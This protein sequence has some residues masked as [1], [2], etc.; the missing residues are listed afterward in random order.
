M[1]HISING[2]HGVKDFA[3][4]IAIFTEEEPVKPLFQTRA[5]HVFCTFETRDKNSPKKKKKR[6]VILKTKNRVYNKRK[7]S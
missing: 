4:V 5:R 1:S 3:P 2:C 6:K 7:Y